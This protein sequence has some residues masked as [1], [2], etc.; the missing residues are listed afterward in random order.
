MMHK[1][2]SLTKARNYESRKN[3]CSIKEIQVK[4]SAETSFF[5]FVRMMYNRR[6]IIKD[7]IIKYFFLIY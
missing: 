7:Y 4:C 1:K 5:N 2:L 3:A 6:K